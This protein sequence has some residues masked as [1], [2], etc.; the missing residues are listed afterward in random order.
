MR[1]SFSTSDMIDIL[2]LVYSNFC[3]EKIISGVR[4]RTFE[5]F[6]FSF[7][8]R[9]LNKLSVKYQSCPKA[10]KTDKI[11][12]EICFNHNFN[13]IIIWLLYI[14]IIY[15]ISSL[16]SSFYLN[17]RWKHVQ[18][19]N[20]LRFKS[21]VESKQTIL[22][23]SN[24]HKHP[25]AEKSLLKMRSPVKVQTK[26]WNMSI[27]LHFLIIKVYSLLSKSAQVSWGLMRS[28]VPSSTANP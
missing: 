9:N 1:R 2:C 11:G 7:S 17:M 24:E 23:F 5:Y 6:R 12:H 22:S 21:T 20:V 3:T 28:L 25:K 19:C 18:N 15:I 14:T 13:I 16:V 10:R 26:A 27:L 4:K 8:Y